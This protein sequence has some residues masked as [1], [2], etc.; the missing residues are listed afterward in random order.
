M[1]TAAKSFGLEKNGMQNLV[2]MSLEPGTRSNV[3]EE[4]GAPI[5]GGSKGRVSDKEREE[6]GW[7]RC[8][9]GR[10]RACV[11]AC[12]PC[13]RAAKLKPQHHVSAHGAPI[14]PSIQKSVT[15]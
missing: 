7:E 3:S 14:H 1:K 5:T 12:M 9:A 13:M 11:R 4:I 2:Q 8:P 10:V 6:E 15:V